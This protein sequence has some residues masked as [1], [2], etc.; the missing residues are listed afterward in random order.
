MSRPTVSVIIPTFNRAALISRALD[1]VIAQTFGDWEV[2]V[3]DDG[4]T[5][6]TRD[7]IAAYQCR[8]GQRLRYLFQPN[9]GCC[10][11]RNAGIEL[12]QGRFVAFLDS[13]DEFAPTKL[14]RQLELFDLRPNLGLVYSDYACIDLS[15][16]SFPSVL[17]TKCPLGRRVPQEQIAPGLCVVAGSTFDWLIREYFIS[18]IVGLV[19]RDVLGDHIRFMSDPAYAE[20]WL[21]WLQVTKKCECGFVNEPLSVHHFTPASIS[22][23]RAQHNTI[24]LRHTLKEMLRVLAPLTRSQRRCVRL[25]L[26]RTDRQLG[27]DAYHDRDFGTAAGA[28]ARS[29]LH[30]PSSGALANLTDAAAH[31][32]FELTRPSS[33]GL[34]KDPEGG[35]HAS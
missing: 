31:R 11:A 21:F 3:I 25:N 30:R 17:D 14:T 22:R 12:S 10:S 24:R 16:A 33:R 15:G 7:V 1:S 27:F 19:R 9:A 28:F 34:R 26:A 5:D 13:D 35:I 29:F 20:E 18:T 6:S 32:I 2:I 23:T 4:S 8:L